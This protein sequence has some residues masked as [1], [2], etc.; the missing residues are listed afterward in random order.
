MTLC[1]HGGKI[2]DAQL[3]VIALSWELRRALWLV[4]GRNRMASSSASSEGTGQEVLASD[5]HS[6]TF[7]SGGTGPR[8]YFFSL[9]L[10]SNARAFLLVRER[11]TTRGHG[12]GRLRKE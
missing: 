9:R 3:L 4:S 10:Y 11:R 2:Q 7:F 1:E 12:A 8:W 5:P 6:H